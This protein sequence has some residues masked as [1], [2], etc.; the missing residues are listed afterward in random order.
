MGVQLNL[1]DNLYQKGK[2]SH[3]N[4][5]Q[6][7]K[8]DWIAHGSDWTKPGF[9]AVA[10]HRFGVWRTKV[11]SKFLQIPLKIIY[12][13]LYRKIRNSYGIELFYTTHLGRRVVIQ[14]QGG[15]VIHAHASIGDDCMIRQGVTLGMRYPERPMD[16]P[17][18]GRNVEVGS[19]AAILGNVTIG[20]NATIGANAVV[21]QDVP[22]GATAVGIPAK[23]ISSQISTIPF[24]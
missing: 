11:K 19:G 21:L 10:V 24:H 8:E 14:H 23:I 13:M 4:L 20:D 3:F 1:S 17:K 18:L 16:A 9:R 5:W 12:G 2:N 6:T 22:R 7:L 15:I